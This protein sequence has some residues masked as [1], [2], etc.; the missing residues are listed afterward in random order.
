MKIVINN[1][2]GGF[3]GVSEKFVLRAQELGW[4]IKI[5]STLIGYT[6]TQDVERDDPILVQLVEELGEEANGPYAS[7]KVVEI[8]DGVS[9]IIEEYD[10][11]EWVSEVHRTWS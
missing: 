11:R 1:C 8:P 9:W 3:G 6:I 5:S 4:R 2:Y 7:Y 10:G